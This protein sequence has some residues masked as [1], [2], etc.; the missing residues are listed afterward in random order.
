MSYK[1]APVHPIRLLVTRLIVRTGMKLLVRGTAL[2]PP[3]HPT[4][5][6]VEGRRASQAQLILDSIV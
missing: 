4:R 3:S 5:I 2:L 6:Y 1:T